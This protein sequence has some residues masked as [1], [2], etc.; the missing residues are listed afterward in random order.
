MLTIIDIPMSSVVHV[1]VPCYEN[2]SMKCIFAFFQEHMSTEIFKFLPD[3]KELLKVP[4]QWVCNVG[5]TVIGKPFTDWV[6]S[7]IAERNAQV[8]KEK[9]LMIE[10]DPAVAQAFHS[11]TAVSRK[12]FLMMIEMVASRLCNNM[13]DCAAMEIAIL[14]SSLLTNYVVQKGIAANMLKVGA[15]RRRTKEEADAEKQSKMKSGEVQQKLAELKEFE[16]QLQ[17]KQK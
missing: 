15:K 7:R 10:M 14:Y 5:A 1:Q 17:S 11:S 16:V 6:A 8:T 2:L 12:Y 9:G 3:D 13:I 4:K